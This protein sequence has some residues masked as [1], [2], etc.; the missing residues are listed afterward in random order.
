MPIKLDGQDWKGYEDYTPLNAIIPKGRDKRVTF[1]WINQQ[2]Y[3]VITDHGPKAKVGGEVS[4]KATCSTRI[5][6]NGQMQDVVL[7]YY[8]SSDVNFVNGNRVET[9]KPDRISFPKK[10]ITVDAVRERDLLFF[11]YMHSASENADVQSNTPPKFRVVKTKNESAPKVQ[12]TNERVKALQAIADLKDKNK[13]KLR[14]LYESCGFTDWDDLA[15]KG[16]SEADKDYDTILARLYERAERKPKEILEKIEDAL[17]NVAAKVTIALSNK[18]IE[19]KAG[20]FVWGENCGN[21]AIQGANI[22]KIPKSHQEN[23]DAAIKSLVEWLK[24]D[25]DGIAEQ[26]LI[27]EKLDR[28][29]AN[30]PS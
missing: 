16:I 24:T 12:N 10:K 26:Q 9:L 8:K 28:Y 23:T 3:H 22:R 13:A 2:P 30:K 21:E 19:Y 18:V 14:Q 20:A 27:S 5:P 1:A 25:K 6:I 15:G 11:L 4:I 29:E 17:L 7:T